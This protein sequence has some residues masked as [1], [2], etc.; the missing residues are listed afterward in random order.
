MPELLTVP[1]GVN[2]DD[3]IWVCFRLIGGTIIGVALAACLT[4]LS[5]SMSFKM[6]SRMFSRKSDPPLFYSL[7]LLA[8]PELK[9]LGP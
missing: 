2:I 6:L 5:A 7:I 8:E 9:V 4:F 3:S 1:Y